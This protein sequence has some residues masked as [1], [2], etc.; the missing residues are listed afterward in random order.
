M[1]TIRNTA[2]LAGLLVAIPAL[3]LAS[4]QAA[5]QSK[6]AAP[7]PSAVSQ[8][9]TPAKPAPA[10]AAVTHA[11]SGVVKSSD[12]T[13]LVIT[14][15]SGKEKEMTFVLNASTRHKGEI[16]P[17]ASVDVRYQVE[18]GQNVATAVTAQPKKN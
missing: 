1:R 16:A 17:G 6:P 14:K 4:T 12:A 18:G 15:A 2:V 8:S 11:T 9:A 13:S 5:S 7:K 3:S 10:K